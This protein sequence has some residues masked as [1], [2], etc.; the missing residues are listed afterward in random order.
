MYPETNSQA[1]YDAVVLENQRLRTRLRRVEAGIQELKADEA[2]K[3]AESSTAVSVRM[4]TALESAASL[5][6]SSKRQYIRRLAVLAQLGGKPDPWQAITSHESTIAAVR[7][8]YK[9]QPASQHTC[10]S[11]ALT[12]FKHCPELKADAPASYN[13]WTEL[14]TEALQP[15]DAHA[16]SGQPTPRQAQGWVPMDE[17]VRKRESL[18]V[19]SDIRLLLSMYTMIPSRRNDFASLRLYEEEPSPGPP[20]NY[21]VLPRKA[22]DPT[23]LV[24]TEYKTSKHYGEIRETLPA[25]LVTEIRASVGRRPRSHLFMTVRDLQPYRSENAFSIW[26]NR[27]LKQTFGKPLTLTLIRHAYITSIDFNNSTSHEL[28]DIARRMQHTVQQQFDYKFVF[29]RESVR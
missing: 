1:D 22:S 18:S 25:S 24:M 14:H 27:L 3:T 9:S 6:S 23:V 5:S 2:P 28:A 26:A 7:R 16:K 20:G 11:T 10:A 12:V 19:G 4:M 8:K 17:I 13:S 21:L 15:L 29:E